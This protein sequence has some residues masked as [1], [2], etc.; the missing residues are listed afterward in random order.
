[1]R[2]TRA[3]LIYVG[4]VFLAA[5][6]LAYPLHLGLVASGMD[7]VPFHKLI[8][9]LLKLFALVGLWTLLSSLGINRRESWGFS[10]SRW[11]FVGQVLKGFGLGVLILVVLVAPLLGL[12][13]RVL[14]QPL[15][16]GFTAVFIILLKGV[17]AGLVVAFVEETW[18]RGALFSALLK[19]G[20][21]LAAIFV[22][23]GLYALVHFI[24]AD[25]PVT[26][27]DVSWSSG[28]T[29]IGGSFGRFT[30]PAILDSC[31][32]L[33]A[34]GVFLSL[35]R[36]RTGNIA[37]CIGIHAGWVTVIKSVKSVSQID[38]SSEWFFLVG[39]YDGVIGILAVAWLSGLA[40]T[41]YWFGV[42]R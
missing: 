31:L 11:R 20:N 1:M 38:R 41:Y 40:M 6:I 18:F 37:L 42:R 39:S 5:A 25:L 4:C 35:I 26:H 28:F 2:I 23:A 13:V 17:V 24:R 10:F 9:R 29:V 21:T 8:T 32:A 22:T 15:E 30:S 12:G 3:I 27:T 33:F 36:Y 14:Y 7:D 34:A 16:I 19:F